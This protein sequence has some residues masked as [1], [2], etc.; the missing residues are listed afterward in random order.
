[1]E[2]ESEM[3]VVLCLREMQV[4]VLFTESCFRGSWE[5]AKVDNCTAGQ[6]RNHSKVT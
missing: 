4:F 5:G 3:V 6:A 1:M 2:W